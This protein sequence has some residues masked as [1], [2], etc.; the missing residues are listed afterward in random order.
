MVVLPKVSIRAVMME[1][2]IHLGYHQRGRK[3]RSVRKM[4]DDLARACS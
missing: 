1:M 3:K 2:V 4:F